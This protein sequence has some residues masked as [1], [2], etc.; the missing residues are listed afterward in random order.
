MKNI[1]TLLEL[2]QR[3]VLFACVGLLKIEFK[4]ES[5]KTRM[6]TVRTNNVS[7]SIFLVPT[8]FCASYV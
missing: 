2:F 8:Q 6:L 1:E 5:Y 7:L 3:P 4:R